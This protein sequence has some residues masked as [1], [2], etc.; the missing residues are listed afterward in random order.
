MLCL[1]GFQMMLE[2]NY[3]GLLDEARELARNGNDRRAEA[4]ILPQLLVKD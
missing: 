2:K 4:E 1:L 3:N